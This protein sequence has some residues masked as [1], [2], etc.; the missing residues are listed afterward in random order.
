[1]ELL[2]D[3]AALDAAV[4]EVA[5]AL[6][7]AAYGILFGAG[8]PQHLLNGCQSFAAHDTVLRD[9]DEDLAVDAVVIEVAHLIGAVHVV[10]LVQYGLQ[11]AGGACDAA[12]ESVVGNGEGEMRAAV[13]LVAAERFP[14]EE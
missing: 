4:D 8:V 12:V 1:M 14:V 5:A 2:V 6:T 3:S 7:D 11:G 9:A 13:E 10:Y